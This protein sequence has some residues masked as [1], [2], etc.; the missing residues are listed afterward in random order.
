MD[1]FHVVEMKNTLKKMHQKWTSAKNLTNFL[2]RNH[3]IKFDKPKMFGSI[4]VL[5]TH[6]MSVENALYKKMHPK[7]NAI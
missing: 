2:N 1:P 3:L 4:F 6:V 7:I 5:R